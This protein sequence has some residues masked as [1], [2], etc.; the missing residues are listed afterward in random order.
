MFFE[1]MQRAKCANDKGLQDWTRDT[2]RDFF[3]EKVFEKEAKSYCMSCEVRLECLALA[4]SELSGPLSPDSQYSAYQG[5][6]GGLSL[7]DRRK[8]HRQTLR[9]ISELQRRWT[10]QLPGGTEDS[11]A[12]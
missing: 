9:K 10:G 11:I 6:M 3:H 4:N 2:K 8:F 1:W 12:S 5:V 7:R